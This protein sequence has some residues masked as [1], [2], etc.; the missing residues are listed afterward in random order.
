[1]IT[2]REP[3]TMD[4]L[5][6]PLNRKWLAAVVMTIDEAVAMFFAKPSGRGGTEHLVLRHRTTSSVECR[7]MG[8]EQVYY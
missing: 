8:A 7:L 5:I 2:I 6:G 3:I 4:E 1:M